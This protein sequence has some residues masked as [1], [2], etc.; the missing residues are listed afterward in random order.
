MTHLPMNGYCDVCREGKLRAKPA[1]RRRDVEIVEKPEV[2]GHTLLAD[3]LM[4]GEVGL[5]IN[6]DKYGLLLRDVGTDI[7]DLMPTKTKSAV[8]TVKAIRDFGA[9]QRW[10]FFGSDNA[11]ELKATADF[12][13]M[14]HLTSTPYRPQSNGVI[15][16][17]VGLVSDG[18][19]CLLA[20]SGLPHGWWPYAARAFCHA[21]NVAIDDLG[22]S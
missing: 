12:K 22:E 8:D 20:Q 16:R 11:K 9:D 18:T 14:V 17:F 15:E 21:R 3:H 1:R 5:S 4:T 13:E 2:W 6:D 19:R 10:K 7:G